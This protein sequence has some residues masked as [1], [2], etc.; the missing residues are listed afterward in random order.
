VTLGA[1]GRFCPASGLP[2]P[3]ADASSGGPTTPLRENGMKDTTGGSVARQHMDRSTT[4]TSGPITVKTVAEQAYEILRE[5]ILV[6]EL[7]EGTALRQAALAAELGVSRIPIREALRQ[8]EAEGLVTFRPHV[9]ASVSSLSLPEIKELFSLRALIETDVLGRAVGHLATEDLERAEDVLEVFE[10]AF[11]RGDVAAW[12]TLNW[13]FHSALYSVALQPVTMN[14]M[15]ILHRQAERY[16]RALLALTHWGSSS[17]A[18]HRQLLELVREEDGRGAQD[19][20][21]RHILVA[22]ESLVSFLR[23]HR[24]GTKVE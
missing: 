1:V 6:G 3:A 14:V 8:L 15:E 5:R 2:H 7:A 23:D 17:M 21:R 11:A 10:E 22:G 13:E 18:E 19:L 9:G 12:G 20:L 24:S 16:T 4:G